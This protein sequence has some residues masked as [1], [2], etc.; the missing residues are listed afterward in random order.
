MQAKTYQGYELNLYERYR[1][2]KINF[3]FLTLQVPLDYE[4]PKAVRFFRLPRAIR[5]LRHRL[6]LYMEEPTS[7]IGALTL[8][9]F[10]T[11]CNIASIITYCLE[12][13][14]S[15]GDDGVSNGVW[16]GWELFLMSIFTLELLCRMPAHTTL[17][18]FVFSRP[19]VFVDF[20]AC[21]PF[22]LYLFFGL[23]WAV[24]DT[25]W[26]RPIRLLRIV[27][28]GYLIFDLKLILTGIRRSVWMIALVWSLT[29]LV[30]F[31]FASILFMTERGPWDN[32][33]ECYVDSSGN[34]AEFDSVPTSLYFCFEVVSSLGYGDIVPTKFISLLIT[35]VLMLVSVSI[36]ATTVAV[37]SVQFDFVYQKVKRS[38]L[39][40]SIREAADLEL[41]RTIF[42]GSNDQDVAIREAACR[43][44]T[45]IEAFQAI[46]AD[47][48]KTMKQ[49][50]ADLV[51]LSQMGTKG[52][53]AYNPILGGKQQIGNQRLARMVEKS[54]ADLGAVAYNDLDTLMW[55]SLTSAEELFVTAVK[56]LNN[57]AYI[58]ISVDSP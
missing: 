10:L 20:F 31:C 33:K 5:I 49:V 42:E 6:Y 17:K 3:V 44:V 8:N 40:D 27:S 23:H 14:P 36:L 43:L 2:I 38:I 58:K 56:S 30:L 1:E 54:I 32:N 18:R 39:L 52:A 45:G 35:M 26:L 25:R 15:N 9:C 57:P 29:I 7:S 48:S 22:D 55:Y 46:S 13:L 11:V 4:P 21:V 41:R 19:A 47:L 16:F 37:F 51:F 53:R 34:C 24:L 28:L 50:R 12:S